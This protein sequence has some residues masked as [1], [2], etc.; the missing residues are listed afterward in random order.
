MPKII[1]L[2]NNKNVSQEQNPA[3]FDHMDLTNAYVTLD[4]EKYS[5]RIL[6]NEFY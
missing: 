1:G 3:I 6:N 4:F 2:Q 5:M